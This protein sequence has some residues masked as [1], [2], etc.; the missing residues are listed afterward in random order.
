MDI[1]EQL[2]FGDLDLAGFEPKTKERDQL[3]SELVEKRKKL[4][5]TLEE[6]QCELLE[7]LEEVMTKIETFHQ[8]SSFSLGYKMGIK[9]AAQ[10]LKGEEKTGFTGEKL[11]MVVNKEEKK[12]EIPDEKLRAFLKNHNEFCDNLHQMKLKLS[13]L[14]L[15]KSSYF[16][17]FEDK[18]AIEELIGINIEDAY[19]YCCKLNALAN[20][21]E[22][23]NI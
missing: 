1:L 6:K 7:D 23:R 22:I 11:K 10:S 12:Y 18:D 20:S 19:E 9:V 14:K 2:F 4:T 16:G 21:C 17:P 5:E 3:E 13:T 15:L 8:S